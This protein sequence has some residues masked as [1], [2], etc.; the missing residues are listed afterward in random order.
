[1]LDAL[2]ATSAEFERNKL[3][4]ETAAAHIDTLQQSSTRLDQETSAVANASNEVELIAFNQV[5][6]Q[7][8]LEGIDRHSNWIQEAATSLASSVTAQ[9]HRLDAHWRRALPPSDAHVPDSLHAFQS[10]LLRAINHDDPD[11][12]EASVAKALSQGLP[13]D[14]LL[15]RLG[16][17]AM[18]VSL[19]QQGKDLPTEVYFRNGDVL[20]RALDALEPALA[21][22]EILPESGTVVLGNAFEDYHD[23]GRRLVTIALRTAG[24]KVVDLGLSVSNERFVA[25]AREHQPQVIGVSSLLLHTAKWIPRLRADLRKANLG[26][27]G[28]VAGGAPFLVDPYLSDRFEVDGVGRNPSDAVRLI[29]ALVDERKGA[30][31]P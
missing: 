4:L 7:E 6:L 19:D 14:A 28:L 29:R 8:H 20:Q 25:A 17:A 9:S 26:H 1:M 24:F 11:G 10:D 5:E 23:L 22:A 18:Q 2:E 27:I 16:A 3:S 15:D 12:A 31:R 21:S 30:R 13:V